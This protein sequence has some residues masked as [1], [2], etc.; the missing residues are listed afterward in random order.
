[1]AAMEASLM[2]GGTTVNG[3]FAPAWPATPANDAERF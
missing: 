3:R 1:M 2:N